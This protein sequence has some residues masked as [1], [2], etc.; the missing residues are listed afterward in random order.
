MKY[1]LSREKTAIKPIFLALTIILGFIFVVSF[2][3][4][5]VS[6]AIKNNNACGC[7][8]P[9]P[10]MILILSS[11]GLFI[12]CLAFYILIS[13]QIKEK[14]EINKNLDFTL[15]F[16]EN[17]EKKIITELIKNRGIL[18]QSKFEESTNFHRVKV[19]RIL[20][21]L[22][23]KGLITKTSNGMSN[24]IELSEELKEIFT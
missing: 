23:S 3:V 20:E 19:H 17:N 16:L 24:K 21:K 11:L 9:I 15:N 18:N 6:D 14:K 7:V 13:K 8:I 12:G 5:Y 22:I 10:Y 1:L 2:S 4:I